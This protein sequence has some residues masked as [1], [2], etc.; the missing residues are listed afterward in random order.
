[1]EMDPKDSTA[2]EP[3]HWYTSTSDCGMAGTH[4]AHMWG[5][6]RE[7]CKGSFA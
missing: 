2:V 7:W 3:W 4:D 1:M 6:T 5:E